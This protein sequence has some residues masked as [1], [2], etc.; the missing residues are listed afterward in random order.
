M[1]DDESKLGGRGREKRRGKKRREH[2]RIGEDRGPEEDSGPE[3]R[4]ET[5]YVFTATGVPFCCLFCSTAN[6]SSN[7]H[8]TFMRTK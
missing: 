7:Q 6:H 3:E 4:R 5:K 1:D 8:F 2:G